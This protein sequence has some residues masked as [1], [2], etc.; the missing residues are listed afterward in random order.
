MTSAQRPTNNKR[1]W[2]RGSATNGRNRLVAVAMRSQPDS[3][4]V[5]LVREGHE[6][7]FEEIVRRYRSSLVAFAGAIV[8][9][10]GAED[11]VQRP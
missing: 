2:M 9:R 5:G 6:L 3:R 7:A 8:P 1:G 10:D 4:L 11:V